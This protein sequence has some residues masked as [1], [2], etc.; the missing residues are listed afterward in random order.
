M[1]PNAAIRC[2]FGSA[3]YLDVAM[4]MTQAPIARMLAESPK[5]ATDNW[6][7]NDRFDGRFALRAS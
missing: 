5:E 3:L 2:L 4:V 1:M 6:F 7:P